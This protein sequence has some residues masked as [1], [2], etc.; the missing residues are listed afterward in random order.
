[1]ASGAQALV[2]GDP[3]VRQ[4][5]QHA[6]AELMSVLNNRGGSSKW[7]SLRDHIIRRD[8]GICQICGDEG[9]DVDHRVER[10]DGGTDEPDNLWLLCNRCH[11][12]KTARRTSQNKYDVFFKNGKTPHD[13]TYRFPSPTTGIRLRSP[14]E[15][16]K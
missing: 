16:P 2:P 9:T 8:A 6:S 13:P 14:F 3:P 12:A 11:K 7:R 4:Y 15:E 5:P 1:M 10:R